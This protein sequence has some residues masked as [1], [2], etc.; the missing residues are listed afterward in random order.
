MTSEKVLKRS[1]F[2]AD[3]NNNRFLPYEKNLVE[4]AKATLYE[5]LDY[6]YNVRQLAPEGCGG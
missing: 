3:T 2:S 1:V 5:N 4:N 6:L